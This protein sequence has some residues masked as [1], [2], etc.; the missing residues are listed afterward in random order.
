MDDVLVGS[1]T[2]D[3]MFVKLKR[4]LQDAC[5]TLNFKKCRGISPGSI[6]TTT[7]RYFQIT[8]NKTE[9][10]RFWIFEFLTT[11]SLV[12]ESLRRLL[13]KGQSFIW[14]AEQQDTFIKLETSLTSESVITPYKLDKEHQIYTAASSV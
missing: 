2:I 1:T 6:K 4:V 12:S 13:R 3:V 14:N 7:I 11:Y 5:L 9:V 10:R 8:T